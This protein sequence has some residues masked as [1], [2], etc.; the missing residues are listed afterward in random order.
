MLVIHVES[1]WWNMLKCLVFFYVGL[2]STTLDC[3]V[4][5]SDAQKT[6][7]FH[8]FPHVISTWRTNI[9]IAS[10]PRQVLAGN[11]KP[12]LFSLVTYWSSCKFEVIS[13]W[14]I[15]M[16]DCWTLEIIK[17][18]NTPMTSNF[19]LNCTHE[20]GGDIWTH[21]NTTVYL[22]PFHVQKCTWP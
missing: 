8:I 7:H 11:V 5:K 6:R 1:T 17:A 10:V 12:M 22:R 2:A 13:H 14:L 18:T 9:N 15:I 4:R 3:Y 21:L 16:N 20:F 19:A